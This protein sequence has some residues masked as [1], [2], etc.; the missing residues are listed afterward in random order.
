M[1]AVRRRGLR[2]DDPLAAGGQHPAWSRSDIGTAS[3]SQLRDIPLE[4]IRANPE[5]PRK[6]FDDAPLLALADSI[7]ERG[8]LQPVIVKPVDDGY[9]LVA[10]ERRWRAAQLAGKTAIPALV[11]D[12]IDEAGS[13][14]LALIENLVREDLSPIEQARALATL[15][16]DLRMT[17]GLL[18]KRLGRSRTDIVNTI[19]LLDLPD[20]AIEQIDTGELSKGH[21][22]ALLAEPDHHRRRQLAR[23]AAERGWSVRQLEAEISKP[24]KPAPRHREPD[25]D[26][27]AA[28]MRLED[29]LV[30]A[31]GCT[32]RATPHRD[33]FQIIL[34]QAGATN[35]LRLLGRDIAD[36][37]SA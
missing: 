14:E 25:T 12:E 15:L 29:A 31:T 13:L 37:D 9:E 2:V 17:G 16:E 27:Y 4:Q 24:S 30:S 5:Q 20:E 18:A 3:D 7:R 33:G 22:K 8:V 1:T 32:A 35:L 26:H 34:D 6:R 23:Q 19:R 36:S 11:D 28:A 10:G 21:G